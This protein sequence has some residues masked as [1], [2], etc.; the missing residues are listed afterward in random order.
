MIWIGILIGIGLTLGFSR[1]CAGFVAYRK[2]QLE[3]AEFLA[4]AKD[5]STNE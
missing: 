2:R 3:D 5:F 4:I 1:L